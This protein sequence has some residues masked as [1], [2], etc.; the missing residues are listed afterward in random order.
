[1][2]DVQKNPRPS[3]WWTGFQAGEQEDSLCKA[4]KSQLGRLIL[5]PAAQVPCFKAGQAG[6]G[7]GGIYP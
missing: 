4:G 7:P 1:M 3:R 2:F 6:K 5:P